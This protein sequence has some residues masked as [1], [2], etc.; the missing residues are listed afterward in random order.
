YENKDDHLHQLF[1]TKNSF[2]CS[3]VQKNFNAFCR[4]SDIAEEH[5]KKQNV[6]LPN[7]LQAVNDFL[8]PLFLT[9]RQ[10][11]LMLDASLN[12]PY[13]F[14]RNDDGSLK[15]IIQGWGNQEDLFGY[16][17]LDHD[18]D[19][20]SLKAEHAADAAKK[21]K[22]DPRR[23]VTYD[24][25]A[26]EVWPKIRKTMSVDYHPM[27]VWTEIMSFIRGSF[28][29][30]TKPNGIL[31]KDEYIELGCKRAPNFSGDR[32]K[33]YALFLRYNH[34]KKQNFL[35]DESDLIYSIY[36]RLWNLE[37]QPWVLHQM[38]VDETQD[39]TQAELAILIHITQNP[40]N[41]FLSGDTAQSIMKGIS[42]RFCDLKTL[43]HYV[44]RSLD[45]V[46][47]TRSVEVPTNM[48]QLTHNY[49]SHNGILSLASAILDLMVEFFPES[50]DRLQKD[51]GL[52]QGPPPVLIDSCSPGDLAILLQ[53]NKRKTSHIEFGAHQAILVVND[54][55]RDSI[56]EEL[57]LGLILTIYEAK[58][59]EFD[60]VLL[61]NFFKD[62]Y[63]SK[64]WRV[65]TQFL[66]NLKEN[67]DN[68]DRFENLVVLDEVCKRGF[69]TA[70]PTLD[71]C[72]VN[73]NQHKDL[74]SKGLDSITFWLRSLEL[75]TGENVGDELMDT[76]LND[77]PQVLQIGLACETKEID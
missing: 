66:E 37:E 10:L 70:I 15:V 60:D 42:F 55:A 57:R 44:K 23:E 71:L 28:E 39:F 54:A 43:F 33:I 62:S 46:N 36:K 9:S 18:S 2:L 12:P 17:P 76:G 51:Q 69:E 31:E 61:Y 40:N 26:N 25:F 63:A 5:L 20:G 68:T 21:L 11:L 77:V 35:F 50:F 32:D 7:R 4:G 58:G 24:V 47:K 45:A 73:S 13:F 74:K 8:F 56:P 38:Y 30:L 19:D 1:I 72:R 3:E 67:V 64:E 59:L 29:A 52:F 27:L 53:A 22:I 75:Q 14:E 16:T 34:F 6:K 41:M 65:V 49:R 48:Y